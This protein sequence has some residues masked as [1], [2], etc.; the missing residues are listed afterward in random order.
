MKTV[1]IFS[2]GLDSTVMLTS[3]VREGVTALAISFNYGQRHSV[4]LQHAERIATH[5]RCEWLCVDISGVGAAM[6]K[7]NC[8]QLNLDVP[9][10][11]GHYAAKSMT[12]TVVPNRNMTMISVAAGVA[13]ARGFDRVAYGAHAGDHH[14][15]HDCRPEFVAAMT[16]SIKLAEQSAPI[17]YAPFLGKNKADIVKLG[18]AISA[19]MSASYS[20]Y[21]GAVIHCGKCGTCIERR[22]AFVLAGVTDLTMYSRNDAP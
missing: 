1:A 4:E 20:C 18:A 21:K 12:K 7:S 16:D 8:S 10:P 9:V 13:M 17:L 3:M 2:G 6:A 22:E 19:P 14:I 15:Y 11:D 5:L